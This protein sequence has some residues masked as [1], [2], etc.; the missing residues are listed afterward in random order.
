MLLSIELCPI[1]NTLSESTDVQTLLFLKNLTTK[2][3]TCVQWEKM[4][5]KTLVL[6]KEIIMILIHHNLGHKLTQKTS[7]QIHPQNDLVI[8]YFLT[9]E[10]FPHPFPLFQTNHLLGSISRVQI[11]ISNPS[12]YLDKLGHLSL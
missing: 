11:I 1:H 7:M 8:L 3:K 10:L 12:H 6:L 5:R 9:Q 2:C 4:H